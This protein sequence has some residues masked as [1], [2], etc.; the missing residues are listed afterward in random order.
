M[1]LTLEELEHQKK[2]IEAIFNAMPLVKEQGNDYQ[3]PLLNGAGDANSFIDIKMETG[4]GKTYVYTRAM[5]ELH[6][7]Y[8]LFKFIILV[9]NLAIKYGTQKFIEARA[10]KRHF[11]NIGLKQ[12]L[13]LQVINKGDFTGKRSKLMLPRAIENF[14]KETKNSS[15]IQCLLINSAFLSK[16]SNF[17]NN[18]YEKTLYD[19]AT[20]PS[21]AV[22]KTKPI[23]IIDEPH[24]FNTANTIY[25]NLIKELDPQLIL[26][27]GATFPLNNDGKP[28]YY[29]GKP[30]YELTALQAFNQN[31]IKGVKIYGHKLAGK[32]YLIK[33]VNQDKL[34]LS[35]EGEEFSF[36][37]NQ[38]LLGLDFEDEVIFEGGWLGQKPHL[39][40]GTELIKGKIIDTAHFSNSYQR[41]MLSKALDSHFEV[42][43][44]NFEAFPKIKTNALFFISSIESYRDE[45]GWL[46]ILF[47]ELLEEKIDKLLEEDISEEYK[48]YLRATKNYIDEAHGGYFAKDR[49]KESHEAMMKEIMDVLD[50]NISL[51]FKKP[52]GSWQIRRFFFSKW[53]LR[54]GWDNP[55]VFTI[56]KLRGSG[57]DIN[58]I[59]EIGRGLRLPIDD[60]GRRL[61][62]SYF[63]H[64]H[65]NNAETK[66]A[67]EL[68]NDI[69]KDNTTNEVL[70][71]GKV[72]IAK[73][74]NDKVKL[75]IDNWEKIRELWEKISKRYMIKFN[76]NVEEAAIALF[77]EIL[78]D[79]NIFKFATAEINISQLV[80]NSEKSNFIEQKNYVEMSN[81]AKI[82][83]NEFV[84]KL[85]YATSIDIITI[86]KLLWNK[87]LHIFHKEKDIDVIN[88]YLNINS[89]NNIIEN[90]HNKLI[91][92]FNIEY[93]Y[94]PLDFTA[95]TSIFKN[96]E[97]VKD[98]HSFY[99]GNK[100]IGNIE[101]DKRNLFEPPLYQDSALEED[102]L[103]TNLSKEIFVFG[104]LPRK[105]I[106]VPLYTGATSTPDFIYVTK[107]EDGI[108]LTALI[109]AKATEQDR[110][111]TE[112]IAINAQN[113]YFAALENVKY[114]TVTKAEEVN[115]FLN[116]MLKS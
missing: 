35:V 40:C 94:Q 85:T 68:L 95:S 109:E 44:E 7:K 36:E 18:T 65:V 76:D 5:Y 83:Y 2:A 37:K 13:F 54:E 16:E 81:I 70:K 21:E 41:L 32:K 63:L 79:E 75:R 49:R 11:D 71:D 73:N 29:R 56:C 10:T 74:I 20:K 88:A 28:H 112:K 39:N 50:K 43:R 51:P 86:H 80:A 57:S 93:T 30:Q 72:T 98:I 4:T 90:W 31:L 45:E 22:A 116:N 101:D 111:A 87:L 100:K 23:I 14:V 104:K 77:K 52:D 92:E 69:N 42:E 6:K 108:L 38:R 106:R 33:N 105:A 78:D 26:R 82:P 47:E 8:G 17:F 113:K 24:K 48:R 99:L 66:F 64:Y 59:Q 89:L 53:T 12:N 96:D 61:K 97:F 3:N 62:G 58:K 110:R 115:D 114:K 55:N 9:P 46:K 34:I 19:G 84:M 107:K 25:K 27:F 103:R 15:I 67:E 1:E 91:S 60:T 102:I